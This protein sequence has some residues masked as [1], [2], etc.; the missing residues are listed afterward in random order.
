MAVHDLVAALASTSALPSLT[1]WG[2]SA[3]AFVLASALA[4]VWMAVELELVIALAS[5]R[6]PALLRTDAL[7]AASALLVAFAT[8]AFAVSSVSIPA[9]LFG[10]AFPLGTV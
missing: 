9:F 6:T 10:N 1:F 3:L 8:L 7:D 5:A 4:L 2:S